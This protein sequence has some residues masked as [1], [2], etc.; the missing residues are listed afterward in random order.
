MLWPR[1]FAL[2]EV[3]W[4][5]AG[6][7]DWNGFVNRTEENLR[8]FDLKD[9]NYATSFH[10]AIIIPS[11][12][13]KGNLQIGLDT[14][15]EGLSMYYTFDNSWP[16]NHSPEYKKGEKLAIPADADH[17]RVITWRDGKVLGKMITVSIEELK[18]RV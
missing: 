14:E 13:D 9:I 3:F 7:R 15:I 4:S 11:K 18:K 6:P 8:R 12:D 1:S 5:P 16:D 17:F 2:S 10:D